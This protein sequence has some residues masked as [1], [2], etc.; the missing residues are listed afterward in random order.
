MSELCSDPQSFLDCDMAKSEQ[1]LQ[2][3]MVALQY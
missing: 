2:N 1:T 3:T